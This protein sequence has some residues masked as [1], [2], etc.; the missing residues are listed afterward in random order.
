MARYEKVFSLEP[1]LYTQGSPVIIEA[2]ALQKDNV[3]SSIIAQLK[4]KNI[5]VKSIKALTVRIVPLDTI[6]NDLGDSIEHQYLDLSINRDDSF[7]SKDAIVLP[8]NTTRAIKVYVTNVVFSDNSTAFINEQEWTSMPNQEELSLDD[9]ETKHFYS[10][11]NINDKK[12]PIEHNDLWLCSCGTINHSY[13]DK[14]H[15]CNNSFK[16]LNSIDFEELHKEAY[17]QF[18]KNF[19]LKNDVTSLKKANEQLRLISNYKDSKNLIEKNNSKINQLEKKVNSNRKRL[20]II[21]I[22]SIIIVLISIIAFATYKN[23]IVPKQQFK[24]AMEYIDACEYEKAYEILDELGDNKAINKSKYDRASEMY[25]SGDFE[26]AFILFDSLNSYKDSID[27]SNDC[28]Y[29]LAENLFVEKK[30]AEAKLA[31]DEIDDYKDSHD[32]GL[33]CLRIIRESIKKYQFNSKYIA[34]GSIHSVALKSNGTVVA[35]GNNEYGQCNTST[36]KDIVAVYAK[37]NHTIGLCSN[38]KVIATGDNL[39]DTCNVSNWTDIVDVS[40]GDRHTV[41]LKADGTVVAVGD[42]SHGQCEVSDWTDIVEVSA[43]CYCTIGLKADGTVISTKIVNRSWNNSGEDEVS[44]WN[45]IVA[46][47]A[48]GCFNVG[49][50]ADGSI[51]AVGDNGRNQCEVTDLKNVVAISTGFATLCVLKDDGSVVVI[52]EYS[53]VDSVSK[54][55]D[56]VGISEGGDFVLGLKSN[57]KVVACQSSYRLYHDFGQTEVNNWDNIKVNQ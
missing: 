2:G 3:D 40:L 28:Q 56:I 1:M 34:A 46:I 44:S 51:V 32:K 23:V 37:N 43:G 16:E 55:K 13:E 6:G 27:K 15:C 50:K 36:W 47:S 10:L 42:N 25:N 29:Q 45:N 22:A 53:K 26:N 30:Y 35:T 9:I 7:G 38:G 21:V 31:Y 20:I 57:G 52:G 41:G 11:F 54:W 8:N 24:I 18:A 48:G 19:M 33:T 14:C 39:F 49:L 12:Q 5:S 4:F 17:Y